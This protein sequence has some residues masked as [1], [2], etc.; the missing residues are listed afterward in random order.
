MKQYLF[1]TYLFKYSAVNAVEHLSNKKF[2]FIGTMT[3]KTR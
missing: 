3:M 1:N 2:R